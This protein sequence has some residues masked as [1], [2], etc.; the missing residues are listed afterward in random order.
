MLNSCLNVNKPQPIDAYKRFAYKKE[1][2]PVLT[3]SF[4][5]Y[6]ILANWS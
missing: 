1:F 5:A 2:S 4:R 6:M 3:F